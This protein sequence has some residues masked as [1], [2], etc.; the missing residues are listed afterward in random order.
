MSE[1]PPALTIPGFDRRNRAERTDAELRWLDKAFK[2]AKIDGVKSVV[3]AWHA[4]MRDLEKGEAHLA[5]YA[6]F[7]NSLRDHTLEFGKPVLMFKGDSHVYRPDNPLAK[8]DPL[9][10]AHPG[11]DV[12]DFHRVRRPRQHV[13]P[14][15]LRL[16]VNPKADNGAG[17][18]FGP[19]T[20][21]RV[22]PPM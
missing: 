18:A 17:L 6:P 12:P 16:T 13:P 11:T 5:Q 21:D 15:W 9:N 22:I 8:S 14:E 3:V 4:D 20:W 10:F 2:Q 1:I 19:F 7:V